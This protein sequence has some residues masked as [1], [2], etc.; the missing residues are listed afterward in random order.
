MK[1][2]T[3]NPNSSSNLLSISQLLNEEEISP[4]QHFEKT[5]FPH[6]SH[7]PEF[8]TSYR[9]YSL[10][11]KETSTMFQVFDPKLNRFDNYTQFKR[12]APKVSD[13][14]FESPEIKNLEKEITKNQASEDREK[15]LK[16][17]FQEKFVQNKGRKGKVKEWE[18]NLQQNKNF[19]KN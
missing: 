14:L 16:W 6:N 10:N 12:I 19:N 17:I 7:L 5:N 2:S 11:K 1:R 13:P 4:D 8:K 9:T 18:K 15:K 3:K